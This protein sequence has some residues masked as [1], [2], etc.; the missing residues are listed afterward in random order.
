[1][2]F[3]DFQSRI[4][5]EGFPSPIDDAERII[6]ALMVAYNGSAAAKKMKSMWKVNQ[7]GLARV[8]R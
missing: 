7:S 8:C 5:I 1:M 2:P 3:S 4:A 6:E